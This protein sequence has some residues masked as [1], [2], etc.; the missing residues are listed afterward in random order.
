M[1]GKSAF[2]AVSVINRYSYQQIDVRRHLIQRICACYLA[3]WKMLQRQ[4][5]FALRAVAS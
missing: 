3:T 1:L 5:C 4:G 2:S